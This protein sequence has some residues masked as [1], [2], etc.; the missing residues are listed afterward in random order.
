MEL[1]NKT[2]DTHSKQ[3]KRAKGYVKRIVTPIF[4]KVLKEAHL[5]H[6]MVGSDKDI[7]KVTFLFQ[8]HNYR[9]YFDF[10]KENFRIK[11]PSNHTL[12]KYKSMVAIFNTAYTH[13]PL[14]YDSE[15]KYEKFMFCT[16]RVKKH[17]VEVTN[18]YHHKQWRKITIE[19][20]EEVDQRIDAVMDNLKDHS[21]KALKYFI[22]LHGGKSNFN[23]LKERCEHGIHG[24]DYLDKI[25]SELIIHDTYIKKVYKRKVE[26]KSTA[27]IKNYVSNRAVE[28]IYPEIAL[29]INK[30]NQKQEIFERSIELHN[31]STETYTTS[32]N[33]LTEQMALHLKTMNNI[34]GG[35]TNMNNSINAFTN[36][37]KQS[38]KPKPNPDEIINHLFK[39]PSKLANFKLLSKSEQNKI[40][41]GKEELGE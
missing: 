35:I 6:R 28:K 24:D 15:H 23:I 7:P 16:I 29:E 41:F 34:N 11:K 1:S 20:V 38:R 4:N 8:P 40:L 36:E 14:N 21:I 12:Q 26:F 13:T 39:N 9:L 31:K 30:L 27:A 5:N 17:Q 18:H 3:S 33:S 37:I 19:S 32:I 10:S 25:P 2:G 22:D